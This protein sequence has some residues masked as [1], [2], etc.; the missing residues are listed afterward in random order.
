MDWVAFGVGLVMGYLLKSN[1]QVTAEIKALAVKPLAK[2]KGKPDRR[3]P[4][5]NDDRK[6]VAIERGEIGN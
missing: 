3:T 5:Y 6:A 1:P 4:K 2:F